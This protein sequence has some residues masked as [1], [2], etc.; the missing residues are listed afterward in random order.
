MSAR[1]TVAAPARLHLGF[2]DLNGGLGR[3]VGSIGLAIDRPATRL[4]IE[5]A[6]RDEAE[7]P[8]AARAGAHVAALRRR[9]ALSHSYKVRVETAIPDHVGLGS[10]TQLALALGAGLRALEGLPSDPADD[11]L[12]LQRTQRSGIGAAIFDGGG[13]VVDGGRGGKTVTPPVLSRMNFP[14]DWRVILA[15]DPDLKGV[16]GPQEAESF[17]ALPP[18]A[19]EAS[20]E[21][22]RLTLIQALP[23][24]AETDVAAFGGAIARIQEIVGAYFAPAQ[25]G[26]AFTSARVGA[27][28]RGFARHGAH[29]IGQSSWGPTG[30]AFAGSQAEAERLCG[31]MREES[32]AL[33]VDIRV[34]AGIN[35]G[36][37]V[38]GEA[39]EKKTP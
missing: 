35:H 5:R 31:V 19:A 11:A 14:P 2:L 23:A 16:H 13:L 22:C 34:C 17:A 7:G 4:S 8:D 28:M 1:V 36:A 6:A 25:G 9:H 26:G 20:G 3:R 18:F 21:I 38:R 39:P 30:F 37:I 15:F 32:N 10:G 29:G 33:G 24:L 27:A 12:L